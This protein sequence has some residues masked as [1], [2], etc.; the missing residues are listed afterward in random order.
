MIEKI[1]AIKNA[2][3]GD[4][5]KALQMFPE[6]KRIL[7]YAC[8]PFK[9]FY[10]T[11]PAAYGQMDFQATD[12]SH[13]ELLD[14]LHNRELSGQA[15]FEKVCDHIGA[16]TYES[17]EVF[18]MILNKDLRCGINV[19]TINKAFPDLI[20][21]TYDGSANPDI[22]LLKDLEDARCKWPMM[23]AV[24]KDGVRARYAG[25]MMSRSKHKLIG[26]DHIEEELSQYPHEFDGELCIPGEI[27]DVAS[28]L[29]RNKK[30]T[31]NSVYFIFDAP[32]FPGTKK[33]R[34]EWL[35]NNLIETDC[36]KLLKHFTLYCTDAKNNFY[37][38]ALRAGEEGIVVY[39]P[40]S[41][42][43]DK[44]SYD[45]MREVPLKNEDCKVVGFFEG[46]GK[47]AGSL[48]GIIVDY[49]GH[50]VKVGTGFKE[51]DIENY[52]DIRYVTLNNP[53]L[54]GTKYSDI[55]ENTQNIRQYIWDNKSIFEGAIAKCEFKE[56][57]K[58]G[59]MRQPR[60]KIWRWDKI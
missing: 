34:H 28:G 41:L 1:N 45:W 35:K 31:P 10:M 8:D 51:K 49:K 46:K 26:H 38:E 2:V 20:P 42:Y 37:H 25:K 16:S 56:E 59:S 6:L 21:L 23:A 22:M 19:K 44:R 40:D 39:D 17:A 11:A 53:N 9:K 29:I 55:L 50:E 57:T 60:F 36:V 18:K 4:K 12:L 3:G 52:S 13:F 48:G 43:E 27:F 58:A 33:E 7:R 54:L 15:A 47:H 5:I 32:S 30:P 14:C 24:K